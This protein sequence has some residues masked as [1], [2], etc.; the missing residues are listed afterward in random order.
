MSK[1]EADLRLFNGG[2][3]LVKTQTSVQIQYEHERKQAR[4]Q[5]L[6]ED[7][8]NYQLTQNRLWNGHFANQGPDAEPLDDPHKPLS[9]SEKSR[10]EWQEQLAHGGPNSVPTIS[11]GQMSIRQ[12][13]VP[14][15]WDTR[16]LQVRAAKA[17]SVF[18]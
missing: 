11:A 7:K 2:K 14:S 18:D 16:E 6:E 8:I 5:Q 15:F 17:P 1:I 13:F 3:R 4:L 12:A 10:R 9:P